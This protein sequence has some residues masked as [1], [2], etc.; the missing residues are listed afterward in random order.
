ML[1]R[2]VTSEDLVDPAAYYLSHHSRSRFAVLEWKARP[3][4]FLALDA[5]FPDEALTNLEDAGVLEASALAAAVKEKGT[6]PSSSASSKQQQAPTT[7][8]ERDAAAAAMTAAGVRVAPEML[9]SHAV[10]RHFHVDRVYHRAG[11]HDELVRAVLDDVF[12]S[13]DTP[14]A[15]GA[16]RST[17]KASGKSSS[18]D[19]AVAQIQ[20]IDTVRVRVTSVEPEAERMWRRLGFDSRDPPRRVPG[21]AVMVGET[22]RWMV[23]TKERWESIRAI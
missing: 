5:V 13:E 2:T 18:P 7:K 9:P 1:R 12:S 6:R 3:I 21:S 17:T 14:T 8:R 10:I 23:M 4:G 11:V 19:T 20:I 22:E 16:S 15:A